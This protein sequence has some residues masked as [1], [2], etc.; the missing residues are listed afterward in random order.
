MRAAT[1]LLLFLLAGAC[2]RP[3][4]SKAE[5]SPAAVPAA[6]QLF[7]PVGARGTEDSVVVVIDPGHPS[8]TSAGTV[9]RGVAEVH[10]AWQVAGRLSAELRS[11]GYR[12]V[13]T[14]DREDQLVHNE[15]R[16]RIANEAGAA[17]MVR[18]HCDAN[19]GSG[20]AVYHPDRPGTVRG[21][22]GPSDS[23]IEQSRRAAAAVHAGM[24]AVLGER[25]HDGGIRGDSHTYVGS[26]QGALTGSIFSRVPVLTIEMVVLGH[27]SDARFII[28]DEG[29]ALMARAIAEGVQRFTGENDAAAPSPGS[30]ATPGS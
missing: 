17:L 10:I 1:P 28:S 7:S 9:Q 5:A 4:P 3:S 12:V 6:A 23:V 24:A 20:F 26:R 25:L 8:E 19:V 18:L 29:Q 11:R 14:K 16:A 21:V 27:P 15:R 2:D 30:V 22:T 13:M